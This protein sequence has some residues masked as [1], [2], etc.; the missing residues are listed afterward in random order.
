MFFQTGLT[1]LTALFGLAIGL[2]V[3]AQSAQAW[4]HPGHMT[5][6]AIAFAEIERARPDLIDKIGLLMLKHPDP[7]PYWVA[8]GDGKGKERAR[9]MFIEAAR[10][11]DDAKFT[12]HDRPTWHTARWTIMGDDAP[13]EAKALVEARGDK[14]LGNALDA[15]ALNAAIISN[16]ES[17][18]EERAL[19]LSW[20]MHIMGDIHQPL[21]VSD[22]VSKD[23]PTG[24]AAGTLAYV[25]DPL[26]DSAMPLHILWDSNTRRSTKLEDVDGYA[27][28]IMEQYPRSSLPELTAFEGPDDFEKWAKE[29]HQ[30]AADWAYDIE[31]IPDPNLDTDPDRLV[32]NM[33][34]YILE[35]ISP[36]EEAPAVPDEYWEKLQEVAPRRMAL[37]G[38]RIADIILSA[39]DRLDAERT[40]SGQ[41]LD[42]M[43][44]HGPA[45]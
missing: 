9:R 30:V 19:A 4:D 27:R 42:A 2:G 38:Y 13:P 11:A 39:A 12:A 45:N 17:K 33:A 40:L 34:K 21:H 6:A 31:V 43:P 8:A 26:R 5:T 35:G 22:L 32:Q 10:W 15:L 25:W 20:M 28:E 7:A 44:R 24:N 36:V 16:P 18:P 14:P 23:F 41:V 3:P 29:S 1:R 37:A